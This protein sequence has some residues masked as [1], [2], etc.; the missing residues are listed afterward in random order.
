MPR[1][2]KKDGEDCEAAGRGR[3]QLS[4]VDTRKEVVMERCMHIFITAV[5]F[6]PQSAAK[7]TGPLAEKSRPAFICFFFALN[8]SML[9]FHIHDMHHVCSS[10]ALALAWSREVG[11][12]AVAQAAKASPAFGC[13]RGSGP[14]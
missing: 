13:V 12:W 3:I 9:W 14:L 1:A 11:G 10:F 2:E 6:W 8:P 4:A 5:S 7:T